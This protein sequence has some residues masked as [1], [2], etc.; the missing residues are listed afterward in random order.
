MLKEDGDTLGVNNSNTRSFTQDYI[1]A[2][3]IQQIPKL[4]RMWKQEFSKSIAEL[5]TPK[6]DPMFLEL[7]AKYVGQLLFDNDTGIAEIIPH[8]RDPICAVI[9][10]DNDKA[11]GKQH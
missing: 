1:R 2:L 9:L 8:C 6:D 3:P 11:V 10:F 4:W 5:A 7:Q